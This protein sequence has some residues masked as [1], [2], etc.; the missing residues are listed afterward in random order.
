MVIIDGRAFICTALKVT[1]QKKDDPK[2][3]KLLQWE[4]A[5]L[6]KP[7]W[8]DVG[9]TIKLNEDSFREKIGVLDQEDVFRI[10]RKLMGLIKSE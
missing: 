3:V 8:V 5:G 2:H 4:A 9:K 1:S 10:M 6:S 7:S